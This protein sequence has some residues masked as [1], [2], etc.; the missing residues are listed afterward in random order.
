[1]KYKYEFSYDKAE[2]AEINV[3]NE[4]E[5]P[6]GKE[7]YRNAVIED[8]D[9]HE[10]YEEPCEYSCS[11]VHDFL[12]LTD[13]MIETILDLEEELVRWRQALIKYL[14]KD[15]AEGLRQDIFNNLSRDFEG[16]SAYDLYVRMKRGM[17]PQ[18]SKE[19]RKRLYR[20]A[21]GIDDTSITYL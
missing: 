16:D 8:N 12:N 15:W 4:Q 9:R 3:S 20:L 11:T 1:M 17:D 7:S 18:Q 19:R 6:F 14:P 21:D 5:L 10:D 13:E 2:M